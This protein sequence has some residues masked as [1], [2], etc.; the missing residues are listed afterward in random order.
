MS[1]VVADDSNDATSDRSS[2][3]V[4]DAEPED[5]EDPEDEM[6]VGEPASPALLAASPG[7]TK[8]GRELERMSVCFVFLLDLR[9]FAAGGVE[10]AAT[11]PSLPLAGSCSRA[12]ARAS[13]PA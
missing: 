1:A 9:S 2:L 5:D 10:V 4:G 12:V 13:G 6:D 8:G 3:R 7:T 11:A